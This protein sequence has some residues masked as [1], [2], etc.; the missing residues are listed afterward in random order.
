MDSLLFLLAATIS[1][2]L[3]TSYQ[4]IQKRI[5]TMLRNYAEMYSLE[6]KSDESNVQKPPSR[7]GKP[8]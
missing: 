8:W 7:G 1:V 3:F 4:K 6:Q 5:S 2:I